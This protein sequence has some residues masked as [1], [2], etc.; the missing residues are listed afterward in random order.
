[1]NSIYAKAFGLY[2]FVLIFSP[3]AFGTVETWSLFIMELSILSSLLLFFLDSY[4][5]KEYYFYRAPGISVLLLFL[6]YI[7]LQ[8]IPLPLNIIRLVSPEALNLYKETVYAAGM[9][10]LPSISISKK[11]TIIE[12]SRLLSYFCFYFLTI[13]FLSDKDRLRKVIMI[14]VIFASLLSFFSILQHVTSNNKIYW[15]R[16]LTKGG[17]LFGPFVNRN[18]Y[19]GLMEMLFPIVLSLFLYYKPITLKKSLRQQIA[20]LSNISETNIYLLLGLSAVV[21]GTSIFISL[22]RTG[23]VSLCISMIV[24]G[25]LVVLRVGDKK[26]G[27]IIIVI[28]ILIILAVGW[29]G[30]QPIIERFEKIKNPE[31]DISEQRLIIWK[32]SLQIISDFLITGVGV[33]NFVNIYPRYRSILGDALAEHAHNDYLELLIEGGAISFLLC[34]IFLCIVVFKSFKVYIKRKELYSIYLFTGSITGIIAILIHGITDFNMH[35]GSNGLYFFFLL[36][37]CV[38]SSNTRLRE[39]LK[40]FNEKMGLPVG[41]LRISIMFMIVLI[42]AFYIGVITAQMFYKSIKDEKLNLIR[43]NEKLQSVKRLSYLA[44]YFDPIEAKYAYS[45]AN[46][47]KLLSNNENAYKYYKRAVLL[48]P[49]NGEYLQRL[50]LIESEFRNYDSAEMLLKSGIKYNVVNPERYK[51]YA[52]WLFSMNRYGD[53]LKVMREAINLDPSKTREYIALMVLS[54]LSDDEILSSIPDKIGPVLTF[55][56]YLIKVGRVEMADKVY[57]MAV[58]YLIND[59]KLSSSYYFKISSYYEMRGRY[60]DA[61]KIMVDAKRIYPGDQDV[62]LTLGRLYEKMGLMDKAMNEYRDLLKKAPNNKQA[63]KR[64]KDIISKMQ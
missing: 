59:N 6:L 64:L 32:D 26:K 54:G 31:G 9:N 23:I 21:I 20:E 36:G 60:E 41:F 25:L 8:T 10:V 50:G 2:V 46:A 38:A 57:K 13:Q 53:G 4:R 19:A 34:L 37:L 58:N 47:E 61:I 56:D 11:A 7:I 39:G 28:C 30:W 51:R 44:Y 55:A 16:D 24:F 3:L 5:R 12:L 1:M 29:F 40:S 49:T 42:S 45:I 52:L 14:V 17:N 48:L 35:I 27:F 43:S 62:Y 22:S 63:Y 18:H 15:L 33:G